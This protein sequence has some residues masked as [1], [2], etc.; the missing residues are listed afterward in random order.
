MGQLTDRQA[1][2]LA[3][4]N[5]GLARDAEEVASSLQVELDE[6]ALLCRQLTRRGLIR[7]G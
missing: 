2:V 6:A 1:L 3:L 4:F 7:V 5:Y